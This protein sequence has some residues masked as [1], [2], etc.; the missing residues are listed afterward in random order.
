MENAIA[1]LGLSARAYGLV[2]EMG[3]RSWGA[4][5]RRPSM[6]ARSTGPAGSSETADCSCSGAGWEVSGCFP[7]WSC[8]TLS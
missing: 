8:S 6:I 1:G 2:L 7:A 3:K 4:A 5:W